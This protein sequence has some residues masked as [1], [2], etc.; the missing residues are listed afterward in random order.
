M[1][2]D[3]IEK[4]TSSAPALARDVIDDTSSYETEEQPHEQQQEQERD[5][6]TRS[7]DSVSSS[8]T[9][10][11][12]PL[13]QD[14][15]S[16]SYEAIA[17]AISTTLVSASNGGASKSSTG[18]ESDSEPSSSSALKSSLEARRTTG[19][20][21]ADVID[22][23]VVL[24]RRR[25]ATASGGIKAR[26][27]VRSSRI[28]VVAPGDSDSMKARSQTKEA[29]SGETAKSGAASKETPSGGQHELGVDSSART[30]AGEPAADKVAEAANTEAEHQS[31]PESDSAEEV[32]EDKV[33]EAEEEEASLAPEVVSGEPIVDRGE[34]VP[35]WPLRRM[36]FRDNNLDDL[37]IHVSSQPKEAR[38][39]SRRQEENPSSI[40]R[41]SGSPVKQPQQP[42]QQQRQQ[43]Q[44]G[45]SNEIRVGQL[46]QQQQQQPKLFS[47]EQIIRDHVT[48]SKSRHRSSQAGA[49]TSRQPDRDQSMVTTMQNP[50]AAASQREQQQP[51]Q[52]QPRHQQP[53]QQQ[54]SQDLSRQQQQP[55]AQVWQQQHQQHLIQQ[56]PMRPQRQVQES[57]RHFHD[58][59]GSGSSP[60]QLQQ[61]P[62]FLL[63]PNHPLNPSQHFPTSQG[64]ADQVHP[65]PRHHHNHQQQ[66]QQ[67]S[68]LQA[69]S[70]HPPGTFHTTEH[71]FMLSPS[72]FRTFMNSPLFRQDQQQLQQQPT[73]PLQVASSRN[74]FEGPAAAAAVAPSMV[75]PAAASL[76]MISEH[77]QHPTLQQQEA[78]GGGLSAAGSEP[79][80]QVMLQGGE[81]APAVADQE[82]QESYGQMPTYQ[83]AE[84][85]YEGGHGAPYPPHHGGYGGGGGYAGDQDK[86][87]KGITFHFGGGPI[88]GGTQLITSPM[89][90]FKHL[91]LP[92]LPN[93]RGEFQLPTL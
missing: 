32:E 81:Q 26:P 80:A 82:V 29:S 65:F 27:N 42:L 31:A 61:V 37:S 3:N 35:A 20:N 52:Q 64:Q 14:D 24:G 15:D 50:P 8:S 79:R 25:Q 91:M 83:M 41:S 44:K 53:P 40:E 13:Q 6:D 33:K 71:H 38:A 85:G 73:R 87:S 34:W 4:R 58:M 88:G 12:Q 92:L 78:A 75:A 66:Q 56:L 76:P 62:Q 84:G 57:Q 23:L 7:P 59:V 48:K 60:A 22:Q 86:K 9:A 5:Q 16:A 19:E 55:G 28:V 39:R 18:A 36:E 45:P 72:Q 77:Q 68:Q 90:I 47:T 67:Q 93:P 30:S 70:Q 51:H 49:E 69:Q 89:G 63:Q 43:P 1:N 46:M 74:S 21:V 54:L 2:G 10:K 17:S 11:P